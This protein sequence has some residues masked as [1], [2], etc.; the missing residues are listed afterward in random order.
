MNGIEPEDAASKPDAGS[1]GNEI[2]APGPGDIRLFQCGGQDPLAAPPGRARVTAA[3]PNPNKAPDAG[4][5]EDQTKITYISYGTEVNHGHMYVNT[6]TNSA[7][8]F[9]NIQV[10][11]MPCD[12][13]NIEIDFDVLLNRLPEGAL[14]MKSDRL[15]VFDHGD[16]KKSQQEMYA[17][18]HVLVQAKDFYGHA[19]TMTY[20]E[21]KDQIIFEGGENGL[22]TLYRSSSAG[23]EAQKI[24]GKTI[25][26]IRST[27]MFK[28]KGGEWISSN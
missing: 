1:D 27:G 17:K 4:K 16:K 5:G 23:A 10:V 22:A 7:T 11:N 9:Q 2:N 8:F 28:I 18:G 14:Y 3:K 24:E 19:N 15:D 25:I 13:P 26:Y 20:N 12:D 21:A 6:K